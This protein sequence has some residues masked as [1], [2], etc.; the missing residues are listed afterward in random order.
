MS[1]DI[2]IQNT[3]SPEQDCIHL[4][5]G[6]GHLHHIHKWSRTLQ[7]RIHIVQSKIVPISVKV[8]NIYGMIVNGLG[9]NIPEYIWSRARLYHST[10][11]PGHPHH[12]YKWSGTLHSRIH[13]VQ[14]KIISISQMVQDICTIFINGLGHCIS[15]Y[16]WSITSAAYS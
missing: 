5:N 3:Y 8:Q 6:P 16:I 1:W 4:T 10:N 15:E 9:H 12:I 11:S 14:S 2:T 7:S 13:L